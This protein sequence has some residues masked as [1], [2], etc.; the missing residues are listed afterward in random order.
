MD[1]G[2]VTEDV[3]AHLCVGCGE[4]GGVVIREYGDVW[5]DVRSLVTQ[6]EGKIWVS[7]Y[8]DR[9]RSE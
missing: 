7:V 1:S 3:K 2:R 4:E 6:T 8:T 9:G 5:D